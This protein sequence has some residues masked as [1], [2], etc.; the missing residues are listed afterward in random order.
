MKTHCPHVA[1]REYKLEQG[2]VLIGTSLAILLI[3]LSGCGSSEASSAPSAGITPKQ[4]A[5]GV[6]AVMMADRT[7]YATHVV[8]N[9]K[10]QDSPVTAD[11]YWQQSLQPRRRLSRVW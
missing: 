10:Q 3:C 4:F 5:D 11:E 9:L 8:T 7:V 6:H 2:I 1:H